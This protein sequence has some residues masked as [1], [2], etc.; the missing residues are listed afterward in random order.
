MAVTRDDVLHI[1]R[2]AR[3]ALEPAELDRMTRQLNGI[4]THVDELGSLDLEGVPP[5]NVAVEG[6]AALRADV[7]GADP[8]G[9]EP[10]GF[11]VAWRDGFFT[12][13]RLAAQ[14]GRDG[15]TT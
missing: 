8:L 15:E 12:L 14:R 9:Q 7:P 4:L 13:P 5:F 11:A 1:A 10:G 3:I 2:L 6:A